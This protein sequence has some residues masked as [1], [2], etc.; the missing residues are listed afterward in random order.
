MPTALVRQQTDLERCRLPNAPFEAEAEPDE[1]GDKD[2]GAAAAGAVVDRVATAGAAAVVR[3]AV[4]V[5]VVCGRAAMVRDVRGTA[6]RCAQRS[7]PDST[8]V[9]SWQERR[10]RSAGVQAAGT[11]SRRQSWTAVLRLRSEPT[12]SLPIGSATA[13]MLCVQLRQAT[14]VTM[15]RTSASERAK[16]KWRR[17]I[18]AQRL[19]LLID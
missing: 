1:A 12:L 10:A 9:A 15:Q 16:V 17:G 14:R 19:D 2:E 11:E 6:G 13:S 8:E 7:A 4:D 18:E 5:A 3:A